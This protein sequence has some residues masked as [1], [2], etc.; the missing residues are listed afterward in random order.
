M[1]LYDVTTLHFE[2]AV[3]DKLRKVGM[4]K[5]HRVDP[6]VTVGL[7]TDAGGFPLDV[8][9]FEG[10]KAETTTL[11]PVLDQF[12]VA[13]PGLSDVVVV[14]DAGMLSAANLAAVEDAGYRFIV[15]SKQTKAPYD[16]ADHFGRHG[17]AFAD[18]QTVETTRAMGVGSKQRT[19]R[20]VWQYDFKRSQHDQ[21]AI[22]AMVAKAEQVADGTRALK[23]DRF[24]K[25]TG[26]TK[27]VDWDLVER[28]RYL[29]GLKGYV[30][31]LDPTVMDGAQVVACY[32]TLY[33]VERSFRITK[34]D[35]AARP[36]FHH[37]NDSIEAHLTIVLAALA[38]ARDAENA[39]GV[40]IKKILHTLR[41]LRSATIT[42][43]SQQIH[44][45]P[46]IDATARAILD[47][48]NP[49]GGD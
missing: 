16:L 32:K 9:L 12:T 14:A 24:V 3:E 47:A 4:S 1:V 30:T 19:R 46:R 25:I 21:R 26:H 31:N 43:G 37:L 49:H 20:V 28:A 42:I 22:N 5:E 13:H 38:V 35:L 29:S 8:H 39:T 6:Q 45:Q 2:I 18:G 40:S 27:G 23:K 44:A 11:V 33:Q 36:I 10:N 41:P 48:I 15:G 17:N 34:S 7:L